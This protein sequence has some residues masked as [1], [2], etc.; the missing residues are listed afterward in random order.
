M[1]LRNFRYP[2]YGCSTFLLKV[3]T[4]LQGK[5]RNLLRRNNLKPDTTL[6]ASIP[7]CKEIVRKFKAVYSPT[8]CSTVCL[9]MFT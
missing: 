1:F 5:H 7:T 3:N 4:Y 2:E 9:C 8:T 6:Q